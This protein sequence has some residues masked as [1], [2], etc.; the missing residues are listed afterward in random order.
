MPSQATQ[1]TESNPSVSKNRGTQGLF[2]LTVKQ[3]SQA[4]DSS[5]DK[6]SLVVDGVDVNNVTI[7]GTVSNKAV[8]MTDVTFTVDDG[9][10]RI[11]CHRW[12]NEAIDARE[13]EQIEDGIYV[14][15]HGHLKGFQGKKQ[16]VVFSV[17]PVTN[18]NEI[19]FHFI[20]CV[21]VHV[22]NT[23]LQKAQ[24]G[25]QTQ[26]NMTSSAM[27]TNGSVGHPVVATNQSSVQI[28]SDGSN[29]FDKKVI[30]LLNHTTTDVGMSVDEL[31][32][33]LN[34]PKATI[35]ASIASLESEGL[36]YSTVDEFH[37]RSTSSG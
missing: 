13:M 14:R 26:N 31:A 35:M 2:P 37:F 21:Y 27:G 25:G 32:R 29:D 34:V 28:Q 5:D 24:G 36:I 18:F 12:M 30:Q 11:E 15:V 19:A 22:Y 9:T 8:K 17:R 7:V 16:L 20:E 10:G 23:K 4:I 1:S 33:R 3:M 6:S